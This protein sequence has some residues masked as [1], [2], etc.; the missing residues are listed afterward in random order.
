MIILQS[1]SLACIYIIG[2]V[3]LDSF[4]RVAIV[5]GNDQWKKIY[6]RAR[7]QKNNK[8]KGVILESLETTQKHFFRLKEHLYLYNMCKYSLNKVIPQKLG[9][10]TC[11]EVNFEWFTVFFL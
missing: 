4:V 10:L 2:C 7:I 5:G 3:F 6:P 8:K 1:M 9:P 11:M